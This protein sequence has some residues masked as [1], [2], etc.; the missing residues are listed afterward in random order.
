MGPE[1]LKSGS[2]ACLASTLPKELFPNPLVILFLLL[3]SRP[4]K[5]KVL[6]VL[7]N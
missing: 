4:K 5:K 2:L 6:S 1:D 3:V 7:F